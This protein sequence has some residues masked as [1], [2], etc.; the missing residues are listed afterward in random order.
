MFTSSKKKYEMKD[1]KESKRFSLIIMIIV[2]I[3]IA[4]LFF[5]LVVLHTILNIEKYIIIYQ[6]M[7]IPISRDINF[8]GWT[9]NETR[10]VD[11]CIGMLF[12]SSFTIIFII[13]YLLLL[14]T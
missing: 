1:L 2:F 8:M 4:A 5:S 3:V 11:I 7:P 14:K 6:N 10:V 9:V 13:F 12:V